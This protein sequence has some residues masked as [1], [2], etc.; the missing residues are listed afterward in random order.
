MLFA[1]II[2]PAAGEPG[3]PD[4]EHRRFLEALPTPVRNESGEHAKTFGHVGHRPEP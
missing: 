3:E 1:A 2:G 4:G